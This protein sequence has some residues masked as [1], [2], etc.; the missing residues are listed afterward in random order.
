MSPGY[1][2]FADRLVARSLRKQCSQAILVLIPAL[3]SSGRDMAWAI[4]L[5]MLKT[6]LLLTLLLA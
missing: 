4:A 1:T 2:H 6:A 3:D 5:A